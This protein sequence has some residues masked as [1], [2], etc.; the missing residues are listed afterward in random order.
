MEASPPSDRSVRVLGVVRGVVREVAEV[1]RA[2]TAFRPEAVGIGVSTEELEGFRDQFVGTRTEPLVPLFQTEAVEVR[3]M[4][5]FEEIEVPNPGVVEALHWGQELGVPVESLDPSDVEYGDMFTENISYVELV[6]RTLRERK[7]TKSPPKS[8]SAEG[9]VMAWD[10][11]LRGRRGSL[12]LARA[13]EAA[14]AE[15]IRRLRAEYSRVA[16]IVDR[17][18]FEGVMLGVAGE[19]TGPGRR[20]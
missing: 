17:E 14:E 20:R 19:P 1:R 2:L 16:A 7:L 15:G 11:Q 3:E 18:R 9:L 10:K 6:R 8:T 5:R 13:R 4:A 12:R